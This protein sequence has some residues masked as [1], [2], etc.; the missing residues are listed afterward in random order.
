MYPLRYRIAIA[1]AAW[2]LPALG[3]AQGAGVTLG[4][5]ETD[6]DAPVEITAESLS[7]DQASGAAVFSGGVVIGQG[8]LRISAE[9]VEVEY[10]DDTGDIVRLQASGGVVF[11][12]EASA[13]EAERADYDLD[14][15][16]LVMS[17]D[18]LLTQGQSMLTADRMTL[19]LETGNAVMEGRV[20]TVF[21]QEGQ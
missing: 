8:Q 19:D 5:I 4:G 1:C 16:S 18:V 12:T 17:G 10:S 6:P 2:S 14:A 13:A 9:R 20:R 11:V 7:V 21:R 15:G 3:L